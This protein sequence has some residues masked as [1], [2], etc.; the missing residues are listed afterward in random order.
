MWFVSSDI[1]YHKGA[2]SKTRFFP[3]IFATESYFHFW[4]H[5]I[6]IAACT[7]FVFMNYF[8]IFYELLLNQLRNWLPFLL[9]FSVNAFL[10]FL[11]ISHMHFISK[12]VPAGSGMKRLYGKK[13]PTKSRF[14]FYESGISVMWEN[15]FSYLF[16]YYRFWL[17]NRI[18]L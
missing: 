14:R 18:L 17:F 7:I 1:I 6:F 9:C 12:N 8:T 16:S 15:L 2:R 3:V 10:H 11:K 5:I 13:R 4:A